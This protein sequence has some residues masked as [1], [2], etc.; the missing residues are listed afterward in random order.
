MVSNS[1]LGAICVLS[2]ISKHLLFTSHGL[3]AS[4]AE[5]EA[6]IKVK[7]SDE[8]ALA[9]QER[10]PPGQFWADTEPPKVELVSW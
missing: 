10:R 7:A 2:G 5:Y 3:S 8:Y 4:I 9:K 6:K 1:T